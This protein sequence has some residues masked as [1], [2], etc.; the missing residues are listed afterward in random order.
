[1]D[2]SYRIK[3]AGD[4]SNRQG[5]AEQAKAPDEKATA[6]ATATKKDE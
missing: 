4:D 2:Q 3:V 1:L 5:D 6:D